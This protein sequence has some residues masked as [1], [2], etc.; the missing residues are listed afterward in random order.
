[1]ITHKTIKQTVVIMIISSFILGCF[2]PATVQA[3]EPGVAEE[4]QFEEMDE[5]LAET[6]EEEYF[7]SPA[8]D[9]FIDNDAILEE[10]DDVQWEEDTVGGGDTVTASAQELSEDYEFGSR[11]AA[12]EADDDTIL[13]EVEERREENTKH[14]RFNDGTFT[15]V[16]YTYPV[17][18]KADD[19]SWAEIDNTLKAA[20]GNYIRQGLHDKI[21]F[22]GE[23]GEGRMLSLEKNGSRLEQG[24]VTGKMEEFSDAQE[25]EPDGPEAETETETEPSETEPLSDEA[26]T[27]P[28]ETETDPEEAETM[29]ETIETET[30][31]AE[32]EIETE[33]AE[34]E[35]ETETA[36]ESEELS[37]GQSG[38]LPVKRTVKN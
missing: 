12:L 15:A 27:E 10:A 22:Y 21:T 16:T 20:G 4:E 29:I 28:S 25:T 35:T 14:F 2:S 5:E 38:V 1:M 26:E 6:E 37:G 23:A 36:Q 9:P 32:T 19:D 17:H 30:E 3:A 34:T 24:L 8:E 13:S 31:A 7:Y 33:P 18:E 11:D